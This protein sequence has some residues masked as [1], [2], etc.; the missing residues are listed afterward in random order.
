MDQRLA[1]ALFCNTDRS[2]IK[3]CSAVPCMPYVSNERNFEGLLFTSNKVILECLNFKPCFNLQPDLY[4]CNMYVTKVE[5]GFK[6]SIEEKKESKATRSLK[7]NDQELYHSDISSENVSTSSKMSQKKK[8]RM[9]T[10]IIR[11]KSNI[12]CLKET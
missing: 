11:R 12:F 10:C 7:T 3:T 8:E 9:K 2:K 1:E 4:I 6:S 5:H